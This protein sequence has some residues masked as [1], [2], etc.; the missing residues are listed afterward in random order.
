MGSWR[1]MKLTKQQKKNIAESEERAKRTKIK[2]FWQDAEITD[3]DIFVGRTWRVHLDP[4]TYNSYSENEV[5]ISVMDDGAIS[6]FSD[7]AEMFVYFYP[8]QI[9]YLSKALSIAKTQ[10]RKTLDK[11]GTDI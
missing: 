4:K 2:A 5:Q 8:D 1:K 7:N 6:M 9:K 3:N 10:A 11:S